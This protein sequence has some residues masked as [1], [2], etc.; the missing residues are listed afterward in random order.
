VKPSCKNS[1]WYTGEH[2]SYKSSFG[3]SYFSCSL[4]WII[5]SIHVVAMEQSG[6][7]QIC[8]LCNLLPEHSCLSITSEI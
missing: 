1:T 5:R 3:F 4:F 2:S 7:H 8:W 6:F